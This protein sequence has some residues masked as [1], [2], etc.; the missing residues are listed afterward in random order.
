LQLSYSRYDD[1]AAAS[2]DHAW[3]HHKLPAND[4]ATLRN[5]CATL[6]YRRR[7]Y[8]NSTTAATNNNNITRIGLEFL[9]FVDGFTSLHHNNFHFYHWLEFVV[10]AFIQLQQLD[11]RHDVVVAWIHIPHFTTSQFCGV[12][13]ETTAMSGNTDI[14]KM[15][16]NLNC[17]LARMALGHSLSSEHESIA[18][19]AGTNAKNIN[20]DNST[21]ALQFYGLE[22]NNYETAISHSKLRATPETPSRLS[23]W[24]PSFFAKDD[25]SQPQVI[26]AA[27][28][29]RRHAAM[30]HEV[31]AILTIQRPGCVALQNQHKKMWMHHMNH[32]DADQWHAKVAD[33]QRQLL[34]SPPR[35]SSSSILRIGYID[36]QNTGRRLPAAFHKLLLTHFQQ[37]AER[38][39]RVEFLHLHMERLSPVEQIRTAA[40]LHILVGMHGNGLTHQFWMK[41]RSV[42]LEL[43]WDS[44]FQLDYATSAQMLQH[45]YLCL[46]NGLPVDAQRI[47]NRDASLKEELAA[48]QTFAAGEDRERIATGTRVA[49]HFL[50]EAVTRWLESNPS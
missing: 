19:D 15:N 44:P 4:L 26:D 25:P 12:A 36:R 14:T 8:P 23:Q 27:E 21:T 7:P 50:E 32:F 42:V 29:E 34:L 17:L 35:E 6:R 10:V 38:H 39:D 18:A 33:F 16:L 28:Q 46:Y 31:D 40:S 5:D 9:E 3:L 2:V 20:L 13:T 45:D 37:L 41:P 47:A 48:Q 22:A 1:A 24:F 30:M 11:L 49:A 43:F